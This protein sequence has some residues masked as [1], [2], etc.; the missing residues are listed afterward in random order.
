[1]E[2]SSREYRGW[3]SD[4]NRQLSK[5]AMGESTDLSEGILGF[6]ATGWTVKFCVGFAGMGIS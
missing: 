6:E 2:I 3:L 1:M 5:L 4:V